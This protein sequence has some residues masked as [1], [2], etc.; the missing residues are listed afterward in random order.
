MSVHAT[1]KDDDNNTKKQRERGR[2]R[3][4]LDLGRK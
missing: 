3:A 2:E 4:A 1:G